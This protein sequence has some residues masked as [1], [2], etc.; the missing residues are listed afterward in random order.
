MRKACS[1]TVLSCFN[2]YDYFVSIAASWLEVVWRSKFCWRSGSLWA[3]PV[4]Q[5]MHIHDLKSVCGWQNTFIF[6]CKER[7]WHNDDTA[8]SGALLR[9]HACRYQ[10]RDDHRA[11]SCACIG[12]NLVIWLYWRLT[13]KCCLCKHQ[14]NFQY[15]HK[16]QATWRTSLQALCHKPGIS[17]NSPS[18][19]NLQYCNLQMDIAA[20]YCNAWHLLNDLSYYWHGDQGFIELAQCETVCID[21]RN[22]W[23]WSHF[24]TAHPGMLSVTVGYKLSRAEAGFKSGFDYQEVESLLT[25]QKGLEALTSCKP[26]H[27]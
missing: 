20:D 9:S 7:A 22:E 25:T 18:C 27:L 11:L 10:R 23:L 16:P 15:L 12:S 6:A 14:S 2:N 5:I 19:M 1:A 21:Q 4:V 17:S 8:P 26:L 3:C 13:L 24:T